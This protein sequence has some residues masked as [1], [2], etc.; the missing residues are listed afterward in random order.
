MKICLVHEEYPEETNFGGIATYEKRCAE[1]YVNLGHEVYVICRGLYKSYDYTENGVNIIRIY[2]EPC[3][4]QIEYYENYRK[5]VCEK[6]IELQEGNKIDIIEVPDWGA[7][8]VFFEPYRKIPLIVR[9]HTPLKVWLKYNKNNFGEVTDT[10][11][12][13]EDKMLNS[14]NLI[15]CCSN[16]LKKIIVDE[17]N[18][19]KE[20]ILVTPNPA[21]LSS[22]YYDKT[23]LKENIILYVGSLEERKGVCV[24]ANAINK[25]LNVFPNYQ[26]VFIGKD[27]NRNCKNISTIKYIKSIVDNKYQ[28][29]IKFLGQL[30]NS[31]LNPYINRARC[32]VFPSLFDNFPYVVLETMATGTPIVGSLNSGMVEMLDDN[33]AIYSTGDSDD[34]A[35]VI[36]N[37]LKT[38]NFVQKNIDR[39]NTLY[40][41]KQVCLNMLEL[42]KNTIKKYSIQFDNIFLFEKILSQI[43]LNSNINQIE[44]ITNGLANIVFKVT[45][46]D[47]TY[48]IKKYM[49]DYNFGLSDKL[50]KIYKVN[51]IGCIAPINKKPLFI[52]NCYY[53]VFKYVEN[54]KLHEINQDFLLKVISIDRKTNE[55]SIIIEK[56]NKY[57]NY[58]NVTKVP[59]FIE[60]D[61][62]YVKKCYLE[63][64]KSSIFHEKYYNHG[65][66]SF[67]NIIYNKKRL[68]LIDFD[69]TLVAPKLYDYAVICVKLFAKNDTFE[70]DSMIKFQ[71]EV[72]QKEKYC[73]SD[74]INI[75]KF[76]LCKILLE[77]FY[78]HGMA[79]IDLTSLDQLRDDYKRYIGLLKS[80]DEEC[81]WS[82]KG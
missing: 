68:Y 42:Y 65:D 3:D 20:N 4:N 29:N 26:F 49:Y 48:I 33:S 36:I 24:L 64:I 9:L 21:D 51:N 58:F 44:R 61:F 79:K 66:I 77:K 69:E 55:K 19:K 32:A 25:V 40:N 41:S 39:V 74:Y 31:E 63:L 75:I 11:L 45:T 8:T 52:N 28:D 13:W 78:L 15:T 53:N 16:A 56:C 76:Y 73:R 80:I 22:F 81:L 1:E 43:G 50:Y 47:K 72:E 70:K 57:L 17:F 67:S 35:R 7:E 5:L 18:I 23:I 27:T 12:R 46:T 6:L 71:K 10:L 14:A 59:K 37:T 54:N 34:L 38:K 82:K 30:K 62:N 60:A 2:T